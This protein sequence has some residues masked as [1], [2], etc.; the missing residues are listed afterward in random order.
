MKRLKKA[1]LLI[2]TGFTTGVVFVSSLL[3]LNERTVSLGGEICFIP[4]I[5]LLV[6]FG[7]MINDETTKANLKRGCRNVN[8]RRK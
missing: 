7:W 8:S 1:V 6:W 5:G 2:A 3:T 4:M